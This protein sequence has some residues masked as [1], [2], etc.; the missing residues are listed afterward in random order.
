MLTLSV[1]ALLIV[2]CFLVLQ[3]FI[4]ALV[5]AAACFGLFWAWLFF[6]GTWSET[7][8]IAATCGGAV[9]ATAAVVVRRH[10]MQRLRFRAAHLARGPGRPFRFPGEARAL[11]GT[12]VSSRPAPRF[13][14]VGPRQVLTGLIAQILGERPHARIS[15]T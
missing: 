9:G 11:L 7:E 3:P 5:W 1:L 10:A 12:A 13:V 14:E 6:Q 15:Q 4:T 8:L 2:G